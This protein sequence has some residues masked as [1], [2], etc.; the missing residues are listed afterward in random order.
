MK[1]VI[2]N[3]PRGSGKD[4]AA[5]LI[6]KN[7]GDVYEQKMT[8]PLD[9]ACSAFLGMK[10]D[11]WM[12]VRNDPELKNKPNAQMFSV[13][14]VTMLIDMS[15]QFAKE[16]FGDEILGKILVKNINR[17]NGLSTANK[18]V[19]SDGRFSDEILPLIEEFGKD[20]VM[21]LQLQRDDHEWPLD[22]A[23]DG[24]SEEVGYIDLEFVQTVR[25]CNNGTLKEFEDTLVWAVSRF[26]N[27]GDK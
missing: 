7:Y 10:Y 13:S 21:I 5:R 26:F 9:Y 11:D 6:S 23:Q 8:H 2:L 3:G 27:T 18:F 1:I 15:E 24:D 14:P 4:T 20:S 19:I 12:K 25:I 22:I 16:T 17:A